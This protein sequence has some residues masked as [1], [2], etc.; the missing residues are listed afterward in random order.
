MQSRAWLFSR[1]EATATP[2]TGAPHHIP[3]LASQLTGTGEEGSGPPWRPRVVGEVKG[4]L[5]AD[6]GQHGFQESLLETLILHHPCPRVRG[7]L[8][9][10]VNNKMDA[11]LFLGRHAEALCSALQKQIGRVV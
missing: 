5:G 2:G 9:R 8:K 7:H 10:K 6:E 11:A 4:P 3:A 1:R